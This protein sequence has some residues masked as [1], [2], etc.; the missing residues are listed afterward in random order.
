ML[1]EL[2]RP[3]DDCA[4]VLLAVHELDTINTDQLESEL[5]KVMGGEG[6]R[7]L[8][9]GFEQVKFLA[10][11]ALGAL[12]NIHKVVESR[13]GQL[14]LAGMS[15]EI[16]SVFD[17]TRLTKL[18]SIYPSLDEAMQSLTPTV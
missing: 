8:V 4:V 6:Q 2:Q 7:N 18:F 16:Y 14:R 17:V 1:F 10:S 13:G 12:I 15:P 9:I 3:T 5:A 11:T